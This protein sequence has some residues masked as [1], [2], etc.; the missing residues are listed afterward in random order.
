MHG[1]RGIR[2]CPQQVRSTGKHDRTDRRNRAHWKSF[3]AIDRRS[4]RLPIPL[5]LEPRHAE[6]HCA[7]DVG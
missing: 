1:S 5:V 6:D 4:R 2:I 3:A 7:I